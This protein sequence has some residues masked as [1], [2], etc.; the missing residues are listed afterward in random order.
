MRISKFL[1]SIGI[2]AVIAACASSPTGRGQLVL[3]SDAEL[4]AEGTRQFA[5]LR[6]Q[7][8]LSKDPATVEYVACVT[9]AILD[10][11]E[12]KYQYPKMYWELAVIER[13]DVNAFVMPG[14]K[15]AV[16]TGILGVAENQHQ[17]AAVL[18]H[19]VAHVT[20][21][22]SNERA[23]QAMVAGFGIDVAAILLG[24]GYANQTRGAQQGVGTAV[25]LGVL[26]PFSRLQE[27]EAD[28]IGLEYMAKAGFDPRESVQLWQNMGEKNKTAI[29]E[30]IST[31]PSGETRIEDLVSHTPKALALYNEAKGQGKDPNCQ[32]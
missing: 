8:P 23:S 27:S 14:G 4:A 2:T 12:E 21:R 15:I 26:N 1:I 20:A 29:P 16:F 7:M 28:I 10:S 9:N 18:G 25:A 3:K 6:E 22:H 19:E 5:L 31:H 13:G 30:F 32:R 17:L 11:M 24:G